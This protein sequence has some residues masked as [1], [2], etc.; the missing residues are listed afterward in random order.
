M[1]VCVIVDQLGTAINSNVCLNCIYLGASA[2]TDGISLTWV[3]G[4]Q[5][6]LSEEHDINE[7]TLILRNVQ[8]EDQGV[9]NCIGL[10]SDG[11][12]VFSRSITLKVVG[13]FMFIILLI[14]LTMF[15]SDIIYICV[16]II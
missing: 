14:I 2:I 5:L 11:T 6:P 9:Y 13:E 3:R 12:V 4:N 8:K 10:K 15:A 16:N 1:P 7:N